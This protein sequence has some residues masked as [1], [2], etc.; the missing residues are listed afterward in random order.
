MD[1]DT[2]IL[3]K[4]QGYQVERY[5][6]SINGV[7]QSQQNIDNSKTILT[8]GLFPLTESQWQSQF[9]ATNNFAQLAKGILY[10]PGT[11]IPADPNLSDAI[12]YQEDKDT[13]FIFSLYAGDQDFEV[14]KGLA[15]A[16]EDNNVMTGRVYLYRI[17]INGNADIVTAFLESPD[18]IP[19][20]TAPVEL[21]GV[22]EDHQAMLTWN[23]K[24]TEQEYSNYIL[25]RSTDGIN[26]QSVNDLP[27]LFSSEEENPEYSFYRDSLDD[28]TTIYSYRVRGKTPFCVFRA[29]FRYHSSKRSSGTDSKFSADV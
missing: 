10:D 8:S 21:S 16:L 24:Q 1:Y 5:I 28:N 19:V 14:A 4:A 23:I 22:G 7:K 12:N 29:S 18:N 3:G 15:N 27:L 2:W 11:A 26:Y 17:F 9:T 25:E 20:L 13:R 6:Y